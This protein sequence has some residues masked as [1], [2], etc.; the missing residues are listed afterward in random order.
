MQ[1]E[2]RKT[3]FCA[4]NKFWK[5]SVRGCQKHFQYFWLFLETPFKQIRTNNVIFI[6][7]GGKELY[8]VQIT[9]HRFRL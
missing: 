7:F 5:V 1:E 4:G 6:H 3:G 2:R 8:Q 9:V